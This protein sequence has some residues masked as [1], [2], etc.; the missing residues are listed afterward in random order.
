MAVLVLAVLMGIALFSLLRPNS[1]EDDSAGVTP[2]QPSLAVQVIAPTS[3]TLTTTIAAVGDIVAWQDV[4]VGTELDGYRVETVHV[5]VGDTVRQGQLLA[6]LAADSIRADV[7]QARAALAEAQAVLAEAA[8]DVQRARS[9]QGSGSLS[10]QQIHRYAT[11]EATA[12]ARRDLAQAQLD[13][14]RLRLE[15]SKIV[16]PDDGII[17]TR[18]TSAGAVVDSSRELFR[19][20]RQGRLE[21]RAEVASVEL[22]RLRPGQ[23]ASVRLPSG[24]T[25]EGRVRVVAPLV[26]SATRNGL[27]YVDLPKNEAARAGMYARGSFELDRRKVMTLPR[28]AVH[29]RD[30]VGYV[31]HVDEQGRIAESTVALGQQTREYIEIVSGLEPD[32]RVVASGG[33]FLGHGDMVQII[34][35]ETVDLSSS[36]MEKFSMTDA[37]AV[38][39]P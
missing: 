22:G 23:I 12:R 16:A 6:T 4:S 20:I 7:A 29:I 30:G 15:Q 9:L 21:W 28:S 36:A 3:Q 25:L 8:A 38:R 19:L 1:A 17:A 14:H 5:D 24:Q 26:E 18:A 31:H 32:V 10:E 2:V 37:A 33:A 13:S 27:A 39:Q 11:A 34:E 35:Q